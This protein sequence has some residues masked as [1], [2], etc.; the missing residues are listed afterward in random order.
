MNSDARSFMT[1]Y[2]I[3][4]PSL[5]C[6]CWAFLVSSLCCTIPFSR[7]ELHEFFSD[8]LKIFKFYNIP[9]LVVVLL[10]NRAYSDACVIVWRTLLSVF[11]L[12]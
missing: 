9:G 1:M 8:N 12:Y 5:I 11:G 7:A 4:Q 10:R 3:F 6:Y 2:S